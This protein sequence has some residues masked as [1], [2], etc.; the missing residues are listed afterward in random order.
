MHLSEL[1]LSMKGPTVATRQVDVSDR[2]GKVLEEKDKVSIVVRSHPDVSDAKVFDVHRFE[3][4]NLKCVNDSVR[5]EVTMPDKT[6][7]FLSCTPEEFEEF[8]TT[9]QLQAADSNRGRRTGFRPG[10]KSVG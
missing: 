6:K 5:L 3:L 9:E 4:S 10:L 2:T 1:L 8:F 7:I